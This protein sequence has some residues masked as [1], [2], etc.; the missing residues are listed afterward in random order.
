M[1][2]PRWVTW[3]ST[4][5]T[6]SELPGLGSRCS[7]CQRGEHPDRAGKLDAL[8]SHQPACRGTLPDAPLA[9]HCLSQGCFQN[10]CH[11]SSSHRAL[12]FW[13]PR[14]LLCP[15]CLVSSGK[16]LNS[17]AGSWRCNCLSKCVLRGRFPAAVGPSLYI[18]RVPRRI[19]MM[20]WRVCLPHQTA[21]ATTCRMQPASLASAC[22][23]PGPEQAASWL[24][25]PHGEA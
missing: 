5:P 3:K 19:T 25:E 24:Q 8:R 11:L 1:P 9:L 23:Y 18:K 16:S 4:F 17:P 2:S 21:R 14:P 12:L 22:V 7:R 15:Q 6:V 13:T 20:Y 10:T